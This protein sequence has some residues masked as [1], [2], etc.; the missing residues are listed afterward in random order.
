[1]SVAKKSD[2]GNAEQE[3]SGLS[4]VL[5]ES[6][7]YSEAVRQR[8]RED[9]RQGAIWFSLFFVMVALFIGV[10]VWMSY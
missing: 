4:H 10:W 7:Q 8:D 5:R 9:Q 3:Y 6:N 2:T 1:M